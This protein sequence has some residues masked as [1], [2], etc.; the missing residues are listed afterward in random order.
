[1]RDRSGDVMA[2]RWLLRD[3]SERKH[4]E[5]LR[6]RAE[7]LAEADRLKSAL[8]SVVS[9]DLKTP[10]AA[11]AASIAGLK[12]PLAAESG[13]RGAWETLADIEDCNDRLT[14]FVGNLLDLTRMDAGA[15]RPAREWYDLEEILGTVLARFGDVEGQRIRTCL[16]EELPMISI[17]GVQ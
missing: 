4:H 1:V 14:T 11:M 7:A 2:V 6:R 16:P 5:E 8:L 3:I 12:R 10:L 17:D 13:A 15:W 9:H